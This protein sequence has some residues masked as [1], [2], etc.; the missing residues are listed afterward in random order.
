[1][2]HI[3]SLSLIVVISISRAQELVPN[4][5]FEMMKRMPN[6][7]TNYIYC[8]EYWQTPSATN[9]DYYSTK[10]K[11]FLFGTAPMNGFGKQKPRTGEAYAGICI[12]EDFIEYLEVGLTQT[13]EKDKEYL[14]EFYISRA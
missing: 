6:K 3:F 12:E 4:G 5:S 13:L 7:E 1:M 11:G 2:K 14:V 10:A 9:A 8:T